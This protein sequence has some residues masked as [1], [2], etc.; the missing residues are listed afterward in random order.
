MMDVVVDEIGEVNVVQVVMGN[1]TNYKAAGGLL[2]QKWK[3]LYW[4]PFAAHCIDLMIEDFEKNMLLHK[5]TFAIAKLQKSLST[6]GI[7]SSLHESFSEASN[8]D[9][10]RLTELVKG[11]PCKINLI[12]FNPHSGSFF[13]PTK[14]ERMIEFRNMLAEAGCV[15]LLRPSRGDDQMAACGQLGKPGTIQAPMLRVPQQFQMAVGS[16][17]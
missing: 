4:T 6:C 11:I 7:T 13:K 12:S 14:E 3:D 8:E 15:V 5:E 2:M 16:S 10:K 1:A 17:T 9:A